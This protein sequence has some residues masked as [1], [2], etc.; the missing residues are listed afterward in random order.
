MTSLREGLQKWLDRRATF[1]VGS[2][3]HLRERIL[4]AIV[5][6]GMV[7]G[8]LVFVPSVWFL[9]QRGEWP[10]A[11]LDTAAY[12][13]LLAIVQRRGMGFKARARFV[14]LVL[15][16]LGA[17][18][19]FRL[20]PYSGGPIWLFT[21]PLMTG[22][23]M[24]PRAAL[25]ALGLNALTL[26]AFG[27]LAFGG[28]ASWLPTLPDS[29]L[30]WVVYTLNNL[31]ISALATLTATYLV[32]EAILKSQHLQDM[33]SALGE[34]MALRQEAESRLKASEE[35]LR[36]IIADTQAGYFFID[37]Q[38][39]FR[40][41]N[42]AWLRM[43]GYA[44]QEEVIGR[45]FNITQLDQDR[46]AAASM[47]E[48]LLRGQRVPAGTFSRRRKDG[49]VG[50]HTFSVN[51]VERQGEIVGLEGFLID[52]TAQVRVELALRESEERFRS[53]YDSMTELTVLHELVY[54]QRGKAVDYRIIDCN[55]AFSEIT[56]LA[57]EDV[58]GKLGSE[59]YGADMPPYLEAY[60]LTAENGQPCSF[61]TY[62]A[63]MG[64]HFNIS[65]FS[66]ARG[67]FATI[68]TDLSLRK[69]AEDA[70][71][72]SE[73]KFR[74]AFSTSPDAICLTRARDGVFLEV[75]Q[76]FQTILGYARDELEGKSSLEMNI[77]QDPEVRARIVQELAQR[78]SVS[79]FEARF[80]AKDGREVIGL[81][82]CVLLELD[83]EPCV[84]SITRDIN[85][86]KRSEEERE[87]LANQLRQAQKMEAIGTLAGGIAHDFNNIL[88]AVLGFAD[89]AREDARQGQVD[90][91][92]LEQ[93]ILSAQRA[94]DLVQRIL[95]FSRRQ[96][97][98]FK[99]L[100]LN[101]TL[102][103]AR[104]I[105]ER[106]LPKMIRIDLNLS[107]PLPMVQADATQME[108]VVLN[109]AANARD[110]MPEGGRLLIESQ[111][112]ML[113][114][115]YC[116]RHLEVRPGAYVLLGVSDTG[117]GM[118]QAT[119]E[120]IFEPFF[121]TKGVGAGTGLGLSSSFGIIKSHGGHIH[122]YSEPGAGST[123]WIYLPVFQENA[124]VPGGEPPPPDEA[125]LQGRE[126]ILLVDDEETLREFGQR[127]LESKGYR[128]LTAGNGE[129]ALEIYRRRGAELD[130]V[131]LD[132]GMPGMGGHRALMEMLALNPRAKVIIA[133]GYSAEGQVKVSLESGAAGYVA[134]PFRRVELLSTVRK[135]LDHP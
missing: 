54:D 48:R 88:A 7:A 99:P 45:H 49:S 116:R 102:R 37:R 123:F 18:V 120:H 5:L 52:V 12:L 72:Q 41:V 6:F 56:G 19:Y 51:P 47:V 8:L 84:L 111:R 4:L 25:A 125:I 107:D 3:E 27:A 132:L 96:E 131:V 35:R 101:E 26:G 122:C 11:L 59:I 121:T 23:L 40:E 10:L 38:G 92:D 74:L 76:G 68:A 81:M 93:I 9:V 85:Q 134:K 95:A 80:R 128:V 106:T 31:F 16:L 65:V 2:A 66:P 129:E 39:L 24:G 110:A 98:D 43:H 42:Q 79:N 89:M 130:L 55:R 46:G 77:Y 20:G 133:S 14:C 117:M 113:D 103:R 53:L 60:A 22:V 17:T 87:K 15:Y 105:L 34:Q 135:L 63:P 50:Y 75:N 1:P 73:E 119:L 108:Q 57:R 64:K 124:A 32:R 127:T 109:L 70:L 82:S 61:E 91:A 71:R 83:G 69:K 33:L 112:V 114:H 100:D 28:G 115:D 67:R 30:R 21:F 94:K 90:P 118:D 104:T 78:G 97:P 86:L 58:I 62:F 13:A 44:D 29:T 36:G 126:T